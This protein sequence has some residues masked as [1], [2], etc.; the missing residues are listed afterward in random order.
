LF[1]DG[2][3]IEQDDCLQF[4]LAIVGAG[5][6]GITLAEG[7][8][9]AG[10]RI[11][12]LESGGF[13]P[14]LADQ[15]L[16]RGSCVGR[17]YFDLDRCRFRTFGGAT[18]CW[19]GWCLPLTPDDF[20]RRDWI[21]LSGWPIDFVELV[22]WYRQA[23]RLV[24]LESARGNPSGTVAGLAPP[25]RPGGSELTPTV[26]QFST[27]RSFGE[28]VRSQFAAD[29]ELTVLLHSTVAEL[30]LAPGTDRV[31]SATVATP[32]GNRFSIR[33]PVWVLA[34]G[35]IE[36][37][38]LLLASRRERSA[39]L[40]NSSDFVGRC[41][42]EHP[43]VRVGSIVPAPGADL[44][45]F[46]GQ[47]RGGQSPGRRYV[48]AP[49]AAAARARSLPKSFFSLETPERLTGPSVMLRLPRPLAT[50]PAAVRRLQGSEAAHLRVLGTSKRAADSVRR[51][52]VMRDSRVRS[53]GGLRRRLF[54]YARA[55]Q[56]PN[57]Q[58][59]ITLDTAR[60]AYGVPRPRL[61]WRIADRDLAAI[62]TWSEV[63][64]DGLADSGDGRYEPHSWRE[65]I[66]GGP[67]H[68]GT[69]R[70]SRSSG[71]GVVDGNGRT[72]DL[73]N[74]YIAGSSV[75]TTGGYANP[76]LTVLALTLRLAEHLRA[77]I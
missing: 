5:M 65:R 61:D 77:R 8:R 21:G 69:T 11:C 3:R 44:S 29:D 42:M 46:L 59:R 73:D 43:H 57:R 10:R 47:D 74:L 49:T 51:M 76:S 56:T 71:E 31:E 26:L 75:F 50:P 55:E 32:A 38:R 54:V 7:L 41:F 62:Q 68:M 12:L 58:S 15:R 19:G 17:D 20:E 37:P 45:G 39:G 27:V 28:R 16:N 35:G 64:R 70:M 24:E 4:D 14:T 60:D 67:H 6:A 30:R 23:A 13:E 18:V 9:G 40:A 22:P 63:L 72:H 53:P 1:R 52:R 66:V 2:R 34:G 25:R 36:N 33:A 48:L